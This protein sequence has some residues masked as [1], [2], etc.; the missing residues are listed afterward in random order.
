MKNIKISTYTNLLQRLL[1]ALF[2]SSF[3]VACNASQQ[4]SGINNG[5]TGSS[6]SM[7]SMAIVGDAL[8][9]LEN[10]KVRL[11]DIGQPTNPV[12]VQDLNVG[13]GLETIFPYQDKL[14]F[15]SQTGMIIFDNSNPKNPRYL[16]TYSHVTACD[17]VVVQGRY[18]YV[19]LR[20]GTTCRRAPNQL[21]VIDVQ[22]PRNP[23]LLQIYNMVNPYGLGIRDTT[24]YLCDGQEGLKVFDVDTTK[25][26]HTVNQ[27]QHIKGFDT[28]DVITQPN[29]LMLI[30]KDG[31]YQFD[32]RNQNNLQ[33]LSVLRVGQ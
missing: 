10:Q 32:T 4:E 7:A 11:F 2:V 15:G 13:N 31:L 22:D 1:V 18:A 3:F 29:L 26:F 5:G 17:P 12:F 8:Y 20:N 14:F 6:G 23:K 33:Q 19:T 24:L 25:Q 28:Y 21:E 27:V 9:I 30:G 16:S